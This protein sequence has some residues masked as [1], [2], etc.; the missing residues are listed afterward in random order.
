MPP[1]RRHHNEGVEF[2]YDLA[3]ARR[4]AEAGLLADWLQGKVLREG[5]AN[6]PL[7][8]I[9]RGQRPLL[10]GPTLVPVEGLERIAGGESHFKYPVPMAQ[11]ER[12]IA[13]MMAQTP[14]ERPP[15][16]LRYGNHVADG[17]HRVDVAA[18]RGESH[19][20]AIVWEDSDPMWRG[21]WTPFPPDVSP[22]F[23]ARGELFV[24]LSKGEAVGSF[25]LTPEFGGLTL[26]RMFVEPAWRGLRLGS[27]ML[28]VARPM[29][30]GQVVH[31]LA[32]PELARFYGEAGFAP[33]DPSGLPK[34]LRAR[35]ASFGD[36][37][38]R[39]ALRREA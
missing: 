25:R 14:A 15:V 31:C 9:L 33:V 6:R 28:R 38:G 29:M 37:Q 30:D 35:W 20:W 7:A 34:G 8:A 10:H 36:A 17:N 3:G 4:A 2:T 18:R 16:L 32:Y 24:A 23:E 1:G 19:V 12:E 13:P 21:W 27:R 11:W 22:T 39:I 26:R 5:K